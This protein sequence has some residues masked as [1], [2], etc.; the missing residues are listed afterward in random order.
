M[1]CG[2]Q[3]HTF[4][5]VSAAER[6]NLGTGDELEAERT[7]TSNMLFLRMRRGLR[8]GFLRH[9]GNKGRTPKYMGRARGVAA[10]AMQRL[11]QNF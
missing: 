6:T 9:E 2:M 1:H 7:R 4:S 5:S 3:P 11:C 8:L 10:A